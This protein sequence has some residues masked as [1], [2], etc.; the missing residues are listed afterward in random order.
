MSRKAVPGTGGLGL[1]HHVRY[2]DKAGFMADTDI[3]IF[4]KE[5]E[6]APAE[7]HTDKPA[8]TV[9]KKMHSKAFASSEDEE[10]LRK[11]EPL[12]F[13][14]YVGGALAM[15]NFTEKF[16]GQKL[17]DRMTMYGLRMTGPGVLID[18]PPIDFNIWLSLQ[19]PGYY[20]GFT[21]EPV[22]GFLLFGDTMVL[23]P[24][25]EWKNSLINYGPGIM[26]TYT[27][28]KVKVK[29]SKFDSQEFRVGLD[30]GLGYAYRFRPYAVRVDAKYYFEKTQYLGYLVS[31]QTEY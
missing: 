24:F 29:N 6:P 25:V 23:L 11:A 20:S 14:R 16:S 22:T 17:H 10:A 21:S 28:Y 12:Y 5:S 27:N 31:F 3:R 30:F 2:K 7:R 18:G 19:K 9:T 26:W 1:F 4:E 8:K 13:S 15:V